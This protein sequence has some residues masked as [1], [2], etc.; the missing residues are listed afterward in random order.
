MQ[1]LALADPQGGA[2]AG[3]GSL[4]ARRGAGLES[5]GQGT[6]VKRAAPAAGKK[7]LC[8]GKCKQYRA[9]KP[10]KGGRYEAGH[11]RCQTC[12]IWID[13][14]GGHMR[15]G[16]P[17]AEDS[18]GWY[19]N[20]CN[21][22]IRRN[23]RSAEYKQRLRH[24]PS[25]RSAAGRESAASAAGRESAASAAGRESAASADGNSGG[26]GKSS[27]SGGGGKSSGS[28]GSS[29]TGGGG[30][31]SGSGG[32][33]GSGSTGGGGGGS[34][35]T[36]GGGRRRRSKPPAREPSPLETDLTYFDKRRAHMLRDLGRALAV[37][38]EDEPELSEELVETI[39]SEF[40]TPVSEVVELARSELPNKA[41]L[42]AEIERIRR[43]LSQVP[44]RQ[45]MKKAGARFPLSAY[46]SEFESWG[47]LLERLG[48]D[49]WYRH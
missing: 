3:A 35:S 14:R 10:V 21:F 25:R 13:Y 18:I 7:R 20:C 5:A 31:S 17:A 48:Y 15:N 36:G 4:S 46:D 28:G 34:G 32:G 47:H 1:L 11:G 39:E 45:E 9:K 44:T 27:G 22:R 12:D 2:P 23:P 24:S 43:E 41:S 8:A 40:G 19:C 42:I 49:P 16:L 30:K 33:G 6:P 29:G 37:S 26:G 38:G